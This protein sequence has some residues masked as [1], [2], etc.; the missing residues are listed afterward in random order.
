[1]EFRFNAEEWETLAP[2]ERIRRC[3]ILAHEAE[4]LAQHSTQQMKMIYS[5]LA[6]QWKTLAD[7][8]QR[9]EQAKP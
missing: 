7:E 9:H 2:A 8:M 3:R 4:T 5:D 6:M 1:M